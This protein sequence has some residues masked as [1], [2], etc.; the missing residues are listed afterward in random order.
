MIFHGLS[1]LSTSILCLFCLL[2]RFKK[3]FC[4][5][6]C[7]GRLFVSGFSSFD[8]HENQMGISFLSR[9]VEFLKFLS[10]GSLTF[11]VNFLLFLTVDLIKMIWNV[12][13]I[14]F[15]AALSLFLYFFPPFFWGKDCFWNYNE[16]TVTSMYMYTLHAMQTINTL[17]S[18]MCIGIWPTLLNAAMSVQALTL[19]I[20]I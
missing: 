16:I 19:S 11:S 3:I 5:Y 1:G 7:L 4:L 8:R 20:V 18:Y 9:I 13:L 17:I 12:I 10:H 6:R 2:F 15:L 14:V